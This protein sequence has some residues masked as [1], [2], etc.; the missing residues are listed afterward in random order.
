MSLDRVVW[1]DRCDVSAVARRSLADSS[2]W[3]LRVVVLDVFAKQLFELVL[4]PD[5]RPVQEFVAQCPNPS[6]GVRVS[7]WRSRRDPD[8]G[9][10]GPCEDVVVGAGELPCSVSDHEPKPMT[11]R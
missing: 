10:P 6:F 4:V 11:G 9:D 8:G 2:V 1:S 5:D 3:P 7:L